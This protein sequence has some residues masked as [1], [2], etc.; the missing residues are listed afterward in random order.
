M[1]YDN[2][3]DHDGDYDDDEHGDDDDISDSARQ[4]NIV[5]LD[6]PATCGR[7]LTRF[8]RKFLQC[9]FEQDSSSSLL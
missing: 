8:L 5:P 6:S 4:P 2:H 7:F 3:D 9:I 1:Q